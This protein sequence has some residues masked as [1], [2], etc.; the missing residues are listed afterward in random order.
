MTQYEQSIGKTDEWY[1]PRRVFDALGCQFDL[2]VASPFDKTHVCVPALHSYSD[3]SLDREWHGFVW[4]NPPFGGRN[5]IVPWV[6]RF[7][8][9]GNGILLTP[10]RTSCPWWHEF[11]PKMDAVLFV[12]E[13]LKFIGADGEP[14]KQPNQGTCLMAIGDQGVRAL[15]RAQMAGLGYVMGPHRS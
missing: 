1:T 7:V 13:K 14:G 12:R 15:E 8:A 2:D 4:N 9:H 10:D 11:A 5:G 3:G 6:R